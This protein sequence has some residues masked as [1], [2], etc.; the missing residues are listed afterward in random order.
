MR[1]AAVTN[2]SAPQDL[3][4]LNI[5]DSPRLLGAFMEGYGNAYTTA[6]CLGLS[7]LAFTLIA[8]AGRGRATNTRR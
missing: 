6:A 7:A 2:Q 4:A 1:L 5:A 8:A 3:A